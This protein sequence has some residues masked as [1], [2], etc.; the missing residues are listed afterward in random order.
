[1]LKCY[2]ARYFNNDTL[3]NKQGKLLSKGVSIPVSARASDYKDL[4]QGLP[5]NDVPAVFGLPGNIDQAVQQM[6]ATFVYDNLQSMGRTVDS[7]GGFDREKWAAALGPMLKL[8]QQLCQT[9]ILSAPPSADGNDASPIESFV[10]LEVANAHRLVSTI[11]E[12]MGAIG[13]VLK[14]TTLLTS[15]ILADATAIMAGEI[16]S[17]WDSLWEGPERPQ[18]YIRAVAEKAAALKSWVARV[19]TQQLLKTKLCL[20]DLFRPANFLNALRQQAARQYRAP[21]DRLQLVTSTEGAL[22]QF[23]SI[24]VDGL[25]LQGAVFEGGRLTDVATES[26][27]L[28]EMPALSMGWVRDEDAS[29]FDLNNTAKIPMYLT[30]TRE[31]LVSELSLVCSA[32]PAHW[33]IGGTLVCLSER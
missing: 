28:S 30:P 13:R 3:A 31:H 4:V 9:D 18:V 6:N 22:S 20:K 29:K 12:S 2:L 21:M 24:N 11:E 19:G 17:N 5:M 8:W 10:Y 23:V 7:S 25:L 16:P 1:V 15:A 32:E 33:T 27:L 26:K 14:G